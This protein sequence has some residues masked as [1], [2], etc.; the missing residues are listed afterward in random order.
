M[1]TLGKFRVV[2]SDPNH[3]AGNDQRERDNGN[4][5]H[6]DLLREMLPSDIYVSPKPGPVHGAQNHLKI[7]EYPSEQLQLFH[8][9]D[10]GRLT[11]G[12]LMTPCLPL[13][14]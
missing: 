12:I 7:S 6:G 4:F 13:S 11:F 10:V 5:K 8:L 3:E 2:V 1:R 9:R 14:T